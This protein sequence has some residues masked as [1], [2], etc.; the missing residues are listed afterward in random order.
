MA[1]DMIERGAKALRD[2]WSKHERERYERAGSFGQVARGGWS[3]EYTQAALLA[4]LDP[5]D[6]ALVEIVARDMHAKHEPPIRVDLL[7]WDEM[8]LFQQ[9]NWRRLARHAV[10]ALK[11]HAQGVTRD[12]G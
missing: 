2:L 8:T 10:G 9:N 1:E 12:D 4:A 6:E 5:E 7:T 3:E 11:Q